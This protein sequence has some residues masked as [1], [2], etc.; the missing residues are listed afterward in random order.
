MYKS[1]VLDAKSS[2]FAKNGLLDG[3]TLYNAFTDLI[4]NDKGKDIVNKFEKILL[5]NNLLKDND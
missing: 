5:I 3:F 1:V 4:T 2:Y